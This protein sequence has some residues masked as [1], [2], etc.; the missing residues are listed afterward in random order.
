[1][2][3]SI[4]WFLILVGIL[5]GSLGGILFKLGAQELSHEQPIGHVI[6]SAIT[7]YKIVLAFIL[8]LWPSFI[9]IYLLKSMDLSLLQP[10]FALV[11]V[12]TPVLAVLVLRETVSL[13]RLFGILII[14][15]GV[16]VVSKS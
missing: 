15:A 14:C 4:Q 16:Y 9:W 6:W 8:Y 11:Y 3:T 12:V 13:Q 2:V 10:M 5:V 1:M 7:N